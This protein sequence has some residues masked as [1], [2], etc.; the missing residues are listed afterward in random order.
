MMHTRNRGAVR[1]LDVAHKIRQAHAPAGAARI[2][3]AALLVL[4]SAPVPAQSGAA[5]RAR[6]LVQ[7]MNSADYGRARD[8][9]R[10][11]Y[12]PQFLGVASEGQHIGIL[13]ARVATRAEPLELLGVDSTGATWALAAVHN[14]LTEE[15]DTIVVETEST[16]P[17]RITG[18]GM[19]PGVARTPETARSDAERVREL[20]RLVRK[21]A[22]AGAFSGVVLLAKDGTPLYFEAVG[23]ANRDFDIPIARDTRFNLGSANKS[24]TAVIIGQLVEE[25]KVSWDDPLSKFI[26]DFPD[27]V[28]ARKVQIKHLLSHT[29][30]LGSYF[31]QEYMR[32]NRARWRTVNDFMALARPDSLRFAP[33]TR[34]SYSNTGMMAL[35]KVIEVATGK[36]YFT[37]VQERIFDRVGM[38]NSGFYEMDLVN[39]KLATGYMREHGPAGAQLRTNLFEHVVKG[40]PA[41]GGWSTAEDILAYSEALRR[42]TL[43][44]TETFDRMRTPKPELSSPRYGYGFVLFEGPDIWGHGG[45]FPGIDFDWNGYGDSGYTLVILANYDR[46]NDPIKRKVT[47]MMRAAG[48]VK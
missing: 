45:D 37:N 21:L 29:S 42:G 9:V 34:W 32:G 23:M 33:G 10:S 19:R 28:S 2:I 46:V 44:K 17:W 47:R 7:V 48:A 14:R 20:D 6:E 22:D 26:P 43:V 27:S 24:M 31:N 39:R 30:G 4:G 12:S 11:A 25:G 8:F 35:G 41:G 38:R 18:W 40:G 15:V 5:D 13:L 3:V 36:D 16:A 1:R